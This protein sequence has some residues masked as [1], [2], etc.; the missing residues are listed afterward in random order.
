M[1][2]YLV[3]LQVPWTLQRRPQRTRC[4][5]IFL[6]RGLTC[7]VELARRVEISR[8]KGRVSDGSRSRKHPGISS[9]AAVAAVLQFDHLYTSRMRADSFDQSACESCTMQ[10]GSIQMYWA[11]EASRNFDG[12]C[13]SLRCCDFGDSSL[14]HSRFLLH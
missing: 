11:F 6:G 7:S 3:P 14:P 12:F 5:S 1:R 13:E 4:L 10:R 9:F 8:R 2:P